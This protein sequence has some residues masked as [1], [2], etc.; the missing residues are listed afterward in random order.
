[1]ANAAADHGDALA[2]SQPLS[3][4]GPTQYKTLT[5]N[6]Y[7][8]LVEDLALGLN[9]LGIVKGDFVAIFAET[10]LEFYL[11]DFATMTA[12]AIAAAL[13]TSY[14]VRDQVKTLHNFQPRLLFV[15]TPKLLEEFRSHSDFD[16]SMQLVLL[17]GNADGV[18]TLDGLAE[19]GRDRKAS[20]T[21]AFEKLQQTYTDQDYAMLYLTSGATGEPKMGLYRHFAMVRNIEIAAKVIHLDSSDRSIAFLPSAHITQRLVMELLPPAFGMPVWFSESL[22]KLPNELR[23]IRP[24]FFVAPPRLW[25]R[26]Y[27]S[28]QAEV[29]KKSGIQQRIFAT[30]LGAGMRISRLEQAGEEVPG[31][32]R[33]AYGLADRI[34]FSKVRA[35]LGGALRLAVSGSAP[36]SKDVAHFFTSLGIP[37]VEGYGLTEGGVMILNPTDRPKI[38]SIGKVFP[39]V[40]VKLSDEGELLVK[41]DIVFAGYYNDPEAT[42]RVFQDGYLNTGDIAE[43]D[44]NGFVYITGRKKEV[45][46]SSNGKKIYPARL[47]LLFKKEPL[48]NQVVLVGDR[49]PFVSALVTIH[50]AHLETLPGAAELKGKATPDL[51]Q[52]PLVLAAVKEVVGRINQELA[53]FEQIRKFQILER[54]FSVETG[55]MTATMKIRRGKI[56][57]NY[58]T[59]VNSM[60]SGK[61]EF[62]G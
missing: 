53:P 50:A 7:K 39:E 36:L 59:L 43:I 12:G 54:E 9:Q 61:E 52:S 21:Q 33:S 35:R 24:T 46:V 60:Y 15:E 41:G 47:E 57:E 8:N 10:R 29:K 55:E 18:L 37:I 19:L 42:G 5:W 30:A 32:L 58:R 25:E 16:Q 49:L 34:V 2:L 22:S 23:S 20:D 3:G 13:Y 48:I 6:Q 11:A 27:T 17:T 38:G 44:A 28:I 56:L 51:I 14:P 40:D 31:W 26:M 1:L 4:K 45:I 62:A